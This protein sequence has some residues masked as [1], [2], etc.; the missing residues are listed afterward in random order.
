MS[1]E[2]DAQ[3]NNFQIS[4]DGVEVRRTRFDESQMKEIDNP[5]QSSS[6]DS[7]TKPASESKQVSDAKS[8]PASDSQGETSDRSSEAPAAVYYETSTAVKVVRTIVLVIAV[9]AFLVSAYIIF[10]HFYESKK[11]KD[12]AQKLA[13]IVNVAEDNTQV[14]EDGVFEKYRLLI[15]QNPDYVGW[16]RIP[17]TTIN[18]PV[19]Q[20]TDNAFYLHKG[21][22]RKYDVRGTIFMDYR[23]HV[24]ELCK[25]TILYGHNNLDSTMFSDLEKYK[26]IEFYRQHPVIEFNTIYHNYKWK[27]ISVFFANADEQDDNGYAI[28]YIY[29]FMTDDSF[30]QYYQELLVRSLFFTTVETKKT[31]KILTLSTCTR[32]MDIKGRGETNAR[33]VVVARLVREGEDETVET[34]QAIYNPKPKHPQIWYD[35]HGQ[36]NPYLFSVRWYPEGVEY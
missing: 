8:E 32:D 10:M 20:S 26:D 5:Y 6:A 30:E 25:N 19:V 24:D 2:R 31:D 36:E 34:A 14:G 1:D 11:N 23:D 33:F 27:I 13:D 9:I 22:D 28:N 12:E 3:F 7:E 4:D 21:L 29:P 35:A 16:I 17:D 15:E 18:H